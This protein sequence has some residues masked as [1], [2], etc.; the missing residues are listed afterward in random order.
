[1]FNLR[2]KGGNN[3]LIMSDRARR[4]HQPEHMELFKAHY[5]VLVANIDTIEHVGGGS[6]RCMLAERF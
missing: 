4:H 3:V 5:K 2:D 1:M 6:A